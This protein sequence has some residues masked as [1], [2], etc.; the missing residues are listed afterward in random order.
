MSY[1]VKVKEEYREKLSSITHID[2]TARLQTVTSF[3]NGLL[4]AILSHIDGVLLN[5]SFNVNGKP[6]LNTFEDAKNILDNTDLDCICYLDDEGRL[7]RTLL[8]EDS[9]DNGSTFRN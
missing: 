2:G 9:T 1:T 5:T 3:T 8:D 6:I 7:W 4:Y